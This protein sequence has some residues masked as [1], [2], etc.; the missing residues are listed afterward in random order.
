MTIRLAQIMSENMVSSRRWLLL[1]ME[2]KVREF[3]SRVLLA[4]V[5]AER[6]YGVFLGRNGFNTD[7]KYPQGVYF[8]KCISPNKK[9]NL[10]KQINVLGNKIASLDIEGLVYQTEKKWLRIRISQDTVD[11]SSLICTW[12][13]EQYSMINRAFNI[14]EKLAITGAPT[15]D[16]WKSKMNFLY[17]ERVDNILSRFGDFILIPSNFAMVISANGSDFYI[18]QFLQNGFVKTE[19][20]I[21][22][23]KRSLS[24][25]Q[26]VFEQF[27]KMIP[28]IANDN[29]NHIVILRPHPGDDNDFWQEQLKSWPSNIKVLYE[30]TVSPWIIASKVLVHNS[31]STGVEAFA[32]EKP[33]IAYMPYADDDFDQNIPN[34]LS[35]QASS[36][37]HVLELVKANLENPELGREKTTLYRQHIEEVKGRFACDLIVDEID[38]LDLPDIEYEVPS[39]NFVKKLRVTARQAKRRIRDITGDNEFNYSYRKQ[40]NPGISL[41]EVKE[42]IGNYQEHLGRFKDVQVR[43]V[44]EDAFCFFKYSV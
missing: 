37:E 19:E 27:L 3:E 10:E 28:A 39:Y 12:G 34:P 32:R 33:T 35:Q 29:P 21:D 11:M 40:K 4:C 38:K 43:Q 16:M 41:G 7:G 15:S 22:H 9:I 36:I 6:G 17:Q 20:E 13:N 5:A 18:K 1:P 42:L 31:C 23:H 44:E 30:G 26:K 24:F 25:H 2:I 8:D 14:P